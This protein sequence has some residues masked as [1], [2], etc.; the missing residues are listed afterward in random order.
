MI[1]YVDSI[2]S[3]TAQDLNGF[4]VGWPHPP[5]P[6]T[7]FELLKN[8]DEVVLAVDDEAH[9]VVGFISALTDRTL[10][11]YIPLLE[12]LPTYQGQ[13]IGRE[14][15]RRMSEKLGGLYMIDL[16]CDE[17]LVPFY[18]GFGMRP[19]HGMMRRDYARQSGRR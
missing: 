11:A 2:E 12:V 18:A 19:G 9:H 5:T 16:P 14:L 4:F 3:V 13:G 7:H 8:S 15:V 10:F 1:C 6:Q 17:G